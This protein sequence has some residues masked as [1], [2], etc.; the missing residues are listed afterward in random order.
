MLPFVMLLEMLMPF[1][2]ATLGN[3]TVDIN[4]VDATIDTNA[5]DATVDATIDA[6]VDA[7]IDA[8]VDTNVDGAALG[9]CQLALLC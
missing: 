4:A 5:V 2:N 3:A 6:T 9:D 8:I 7:T 1:C